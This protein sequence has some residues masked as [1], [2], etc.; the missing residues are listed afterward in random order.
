MP[1]KDL[2][3]GIAEPDPTPIVDSAGS[4]ESVI[5]NNSS[6]LEMSGSGYDY[7]SVEE[8]EC[9]MFLEETLHSLDTE[10]DSGLSTDETEAVE[11]SKLPR[12][13]PTRDIPK[14]LDPEYLE[15]NKRIDPKDNT[16]LSGSIP[17]VILSP[18]HHS[19]PKNINAKNTVQASKIFVAEAAETNAD[20]L[21][22]LPQLHSTSWG[23]SKQGTLNIPNELPEIT[24]QGRVSEL[25]SVV[26]PPPEPFQ[27]QRQSHIIIGYEP[28]HAESGATSH[29]EFKRNQGVTEEYEARAVQQELSPEMMETATGKESYLKSVSPK[30]NKKSSEQIISHQETDHKHILEESQLDSSFKQGP[31]TA[32]KPRK[33]P[34]NIILKTSKSNVVSLN[35]DPTHKIKVS[36][37]S[38]GRPRA[39]TGDFS[40]EKTYALQKEQGRARREALEKLGLPLDNEK[41]P[42]DQV[43]KTSVYSKPRETS[44]TGST[45]NLNMND[46]TLNKKSVQQ[47]NQIDGKDVQPTEISIPSVKQANFKSNTLERSGVGLSSCISSGKEGQQ[48]KNNKISFLN[49]ITPSFLR[50][51][52][53]RPASL[54]TGKDFVDLKE[55]KLHNVE[56]DKNYERRSYPLQHPSKLPRPP[57]VSV[58]ITPKGTTEEHRREALKKLGLLKE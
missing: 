21:K 17:A 43:I 38:S 44:C 46:I 54:G 31:P 7:L 49:K 41:N 40:M 58:Q 25:E 39:A 29:Y 9:L 37:P 36:L 1:K 50:N 51:N 28:I 11:P 5:S 45:E 13:W 42:D 14:E 53:M 47:S 26:I 32:P 48:F 35:V 27:D 12:T 24:T 22:T 2:W 52:R 34:P 55:N 4:C 19:L 57:C 30:C 16:S 6:S 3:V 23:S 33:L 10:A 20:D 15:K 8:K 56:L 18:G